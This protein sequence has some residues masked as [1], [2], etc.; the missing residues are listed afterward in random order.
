MSYLL[1][2]MGG[3]PPEEYPVKPGDI[4]EHIKDPGINGIVK[5]IDNNLCHPTTC[6][7]WWEDASGDPDSPA[8]WDI[9]WT[10]KIVRCA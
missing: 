10:N 4:V 9:Q 5:H 2:H 3:Y 7:I 8:T 6:N 1:D